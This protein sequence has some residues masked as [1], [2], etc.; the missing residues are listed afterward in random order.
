MIIDVLPQI[1]EEVA[2]VT[3]SAIKMGVTVDWLDETL[4][5]IANKKKHLDLLRRSTELT[6]DFEQL[7]C[8]R[9]EIT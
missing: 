1:L 8:W 4:C 7:H 3:A 6:K 5:R 9:D 2:D